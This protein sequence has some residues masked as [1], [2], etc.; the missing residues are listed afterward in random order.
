MISICTNVLDWNFGLREALPTW[1][2]FPCDE[3]VIFDF[4][5]GKEFAKDIVDKN[6][7]PRI[8]L[9]VPAEQ[10]SYNPSIGRN[11]SINYAS[12]DVIFYLDADVKIKNPNIDFSKVKSNCLMQGV[13]FRGVP[14]EPVKGKK[15]EYCYS[16]FGDEKQL[17]LSSISGSSIFLKKNFQEINGFDERLEGWGCVDYDFYKRLH[18]LGIKHFHF[19]ENDLEHVDHDDK[20]RVKNFE[21]KNI[22]VSN[23]INLDITK[24]KKWDS[25]FAQKKVQVKRTY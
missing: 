24:Q 7:D 25:T 11:V 6:S 10:L 21:I 12:G 15:W 13:P 17:F 3:I 23:D 22:W 14:T 2:K 8:K 1:L 16:I 4:N 5:C 20:T 18:T 9:I 19:L